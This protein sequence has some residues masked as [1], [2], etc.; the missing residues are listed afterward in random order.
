[1][2][3]GTFR[4]EGLIPAGHEDPA[5]VRV[6]LDGITAARLTRLAGLQLAEFGADDSRVIVIDR[7]EIAMADMRI[8][9]VE[10]LLLQLAEGI[11]AAARIA[12]ASAGDGVLIFASAGARLAAWLR[13]ILRGE[14][15]DR[16]WFSDFAGLA[17]LPQSAALR[18]ALLRD[19]AVGREALTTFPAS[20]RARLC[21]ALTEIDAG[22]VFDAIIDTLPP[23]EGGAMWE[24]VFALPKD[25]A[26]SARTGAA[27]HALATILAGDTEPPSRAIRSAITLR[28]LLYRH[29]GRA[30]ADAVRMRDGRGLGALLPEASVADIAR[31]LSLTDAAQ[32]AVIALCATA[33]GD[34]L[35]PA[36]ASFTRHGGLLLLW[37]H[38]PTFAV[39]GLP[40]APGQPEGVLSLLA[41]A[42]I[43]P[44][45]EACSALAEDVLRA[46]FGVDPRAGMAVLAAWL[47]EVPPRA[48]MAAPRRPA[49]IAGLPEPF[50]AARRQ[51]RALISAAKQALADFARRLPGFAGSS[52]AFLRDNL[53]AIGARVTV[54]PGMVQAVLERPP[55]DV[56]LA[57]SGLGDRAAPLPDGRLLILERER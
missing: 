18:T 40:E 14:P 2:T 45:R 49:D 31:L 28:A 51:H 57:I 47:A 4:L 48:I 46:A 8:D 35:T 42:S 54:S 1:M 16:W 3:I 20:E 27:L 24:A 26:D 33:P 19:A 11:A 6:A 53:L 12:H 37:P 52:A 36:T 34:A 32:A 13:A 44:E 21:I 50:R 55:L 10:W 23:G 30:L 56:L 7:L 25:F 43:L 22:L 41:L 29:A 17:L 38:L 15:V 5:R 9:D 39:D